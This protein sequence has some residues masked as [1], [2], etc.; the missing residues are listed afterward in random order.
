MADPQIAATFVHIDL[1][2]MQHTERFPQEIYYQFIN[3]SS[4][5]STDLTIVS[6]VSKSWLSHARKYLFRRF[7]VSSLIFNEDP[8]RYAIME[9]SFE[10]FI[11]TLGI[12]CCVKGFLIT[13]FSWSVASKFCG[14][15]RQMISAPLTETRH[16]GKLRLTEFD[17]TFLDCRFKSCDFNAITTLTNLLRSSRSGI[18]R[19]ALENIDV[20]VPNEDHPIRLEAPT[21]D[22]F[23]CFTAYAPSLHALCIWN[24]GCK[25]SFD[26]R[27]L[28]N[29][30]SDLPVLHAAL[31][32]PTGCIE[33]LDTGNLP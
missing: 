12:V 25:Y 10:H 17:F 22:P 5:S 3:Q 4:D 11:R 31:S 30:V 26:P 1:P 32:R 14:P 8:E 7:R 9:D 2:Y 21:L 27:M 16:P 6:L 13:P 18:Q 20:Y 28:I 15:L 33:A 23:E 19:L 24:L 29:K